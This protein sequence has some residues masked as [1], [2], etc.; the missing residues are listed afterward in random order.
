M[1]HR[2]NEQKTAKPKENFNAT[3]VVLLSGNLSDLGLRFPRCGFL[4]QSTTEA[5][6]LPVS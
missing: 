1:N 4:S 2:R 3:N 5:S 6:T